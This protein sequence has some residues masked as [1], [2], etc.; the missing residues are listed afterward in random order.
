MEAEVRA[1][2]VAMREWRK[3]WR[4]VEST[5][6]AL[7]SG[8]HP[9]FDERPQGELM[10]VDAVTA[11]EEGV[12][13]GFFRELRVSP[14]KRHVAFLWQREVGRPRAGEKLGWPSR[15]REELLDVITADG[16]A[17]ATME[18]VEQPLSGSLQWS[19]DSAE[20][21]V[22]GTGTSGK[23]PRRVCRYRLADGRVEPLTD[24]S[25]D[26]SSSAGESP[27]IATADP[28]SPMTGIKPA[29]KITGKS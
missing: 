10:L 2:E 27:P 8:A 20:L 3:A 24:A 12:M 21:A 18:A 14:N 19:P 15:E 11:R 16:D 4:G 17:V 9:T 23:A 29:R 28:S 25:L 22:I 7:E 6:S 1:A 26:S 5:R 13:R